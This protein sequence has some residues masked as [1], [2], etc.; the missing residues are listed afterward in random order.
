MNRIDQDKKFVLNL[1]SKTLNDKEIM[2]LAKGLKFIPATYISRRN[3]MKDF[4]KFERNLR[5]KYFFE[6]NKEIK[7]KEH[8]FKL[9]SKFEVPIIGDNAVENYLFH[10]K[11]ALSEYIPDTKYKHIPKQ[12][13]ECIRKLRNDPSLCIHK[14]D[15]SNVTVVQNRSDY[16]EEGE[17][18]LNDGIH[19]ERIDEINTQETIDVI[20]QTAYKMKENNEI[21]DI[22]LKFLTNEDKNSKTPKAYFLPKIHKLNKSTLDR[23]IN[24]AHSNEKIIV[25]GRPIIA[26]CSGPLEKVAKF[27]DY[28]L[29]PIVKK[30]ETYLSDTGDFIRQIESTKIETDDILVSYDITSLYTNL[31]FSEIIDSVKHALENDDTV[32]E[33][34][35]PSTDNLINILQIILSNNEFTFNEKCYRQIVGVAM[36]SNVAPETSDIA[37]YNH[38]NKIMEKFPYRNKI[39]FH[40]RMRD[41]GCLIYG[42]P[43]KEIKEL[44]EMANKSHEFLKFTYETDMK[45]LKF[46]D[47][48]IYK[49][50]RFS[51]RKIL[52]IKCHTKISEQ[53]Q[54]LHRKSKHPKNVFKSFIKGEGIRILRNTS[55]SNEFSKRLALFVNKLTKRGYNEQEVW[56]TLNTI[57][58]VDRQRKLQQKYKNKNKN[59]MKNMFVTTYHR[60]AE[61]L[62]KIMIK[63]W[64]IIRK[65]RIT[66]NIF[67]TKPRLAF[68]KSKSIG[69]MIIKH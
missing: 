67:K 40:K 41:D 55:S 44:F 7:V 32:Y 30:Q 3:L 42:G 16:T 46:L 59:I 54:Y 47:T 50:E 28:F 34:K 63:F 53:F 48:E 66:K 27:L 15:K 17:R 58:H 11:H 26:Q 35:K 22:T 65:D 24:N 23:C 38:I 9:K 29:L 45:C 37:I 51:D 18:Q 20:R 43:I 25:P 5:L 56:K 1:S 19:Y 21:D 57:Q 13:L 10:T 69:E 33:I 6:I 68:T 14:A 49:G 64:Y 36:G 39:K 62:Q 2:V 60:K 12:E 8:P 4:C 31:K 61:L 52:D